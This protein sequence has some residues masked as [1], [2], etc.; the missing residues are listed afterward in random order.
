MKVLVKEF[1][2]FIHFFSTLRIFQMQKL[3]YVSSVFYTHNIEIAYFSV[4]Y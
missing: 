4:E 2:V 1:Y 3:K